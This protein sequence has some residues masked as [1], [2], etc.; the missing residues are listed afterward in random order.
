MFKD[1]SINEYDDIL[2]SQQPTP[3]GGSALAIVAGHACSL[4]EMACMISLNKFG[5][6]YDYK[7]ILETNKKTVA[8]C[9]KHLHKL[10]DD[11]SDA[12]NTILSAMKMPKS[13]QEEVTKRKSQLQKSYHKAA[14]VPIEVMQCCKLAIDCAEKCAPYTYKYVDSDRV[15]GANLLACVIKNSIENVLANTTLIADEQLKN[16]LENQA[17]TIIAE[18]K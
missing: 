18:L 3:G 7:E 13:N 16:Q 10:A 17:N 2:A 8:M 1:L 5:P 12:F 14:L 6:D 4:I 15:I 11:D 9:K